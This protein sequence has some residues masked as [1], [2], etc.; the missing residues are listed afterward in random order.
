M[1]RMAGPSQQE[2]ARKYSFLPAARGIRRTFRALWALVGLM[3]VLIGGVAVT[4]L[5]TRFT[6][7]VP[8]PARFD[9]LALIVT[10]VIL[11]LAF[12]SIC[13]VCATYVTSS[14]IA[15]DSTGVTLYLTDSRSRFVP[16]ENVDRDGI[17]P[18]KPRPMFRPVTD[19][20]AAYAVPAR[21]L[22]LLHVLTGYYYGVG[23]SGVFVVH[24]DHEGYE[25]I[26]EELKA[27]SAQ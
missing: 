20:V 17:R 24:S 27:G 11:Y 13:S 1:M 7:G 10:A 6:D 26:I 21:K 3:A 9:A 8:S 2:P 18:V 22:S 23:F 16:W 14:D 4:A 5:V 25:Q 12:R 19:N 15:L